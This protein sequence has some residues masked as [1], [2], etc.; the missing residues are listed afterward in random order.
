MQQ[1][2]SDGIT[3]HV[4]QEG[5]LR[6]P[7]AFDLDTNELAAAD[8]REHMLQIPRFK[9]QRYRVEPV[10]IHHTRHPP[11]PSQSLH[12]LAY[13]RPPF[14]YQFNLLCLLIHSPPRFF[15]FQSD[16]RDLARPHGCAIV[17]QTVAFVKRDS[18]APAL[19]NTGLVTT[20]PT[21][22]RA[23]ERILWDADERRQ[24]LIF[25]FDL[26]K[27]ALIC[28]RSQIWRNG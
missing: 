4:T 14:G 10:S 7:L 19:K 12:L 20:Q 1:G 6:P 13:H 5:H 27:S 2:A 25:E 9:L 3:L 18:I 15:V 26:R 21:S 11:L 23:L 17:A 16:G 28:V 22:D 8:V 24:T